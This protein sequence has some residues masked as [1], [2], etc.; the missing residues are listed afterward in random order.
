MAE[1]F[2]SLL[3]RRVSS[4][5]SL[6]CIGL[7]P[8]AA[9]LPEPSAAAALTFCLEIVAKT[10]PYAAAFKPNCAFF[11]AFGAA[12]IEA[13]LEVVR[14]IP[15][16]VPII[17]DCKR[18]DIDTTAQAY[19]SAAYDILSVRG[20]G[21]PSAVTL[22]PYMGWDSVQPFV[23][24]P[25][26]DKAA[27]VLCK[28]SNPSSSDIQNKTTGG[29]FVFEMVAK[30]CCEW[31]SRGGGIGLVAGATDTAALA[32][33][34]AA[35]PDLWILCPG[36]G[37][38][39]GEP[40]PVCQAG[41]RADGSGLLVSVSRGI[42]KAA[43]MA[44]AAQDL[45]REVNACRAAKA[46]SSASSASAASAASGADVAVEGYQVDFINLALSKNVLQFGQFTLKSGRVS[47]YFFNAGLFSCGQS[48]HLLSRF[49]AQA[50]RASGVSFDVIFG[51]A[52][53]GIPLA[54]SIA[55]AWYDL[56]G[57]SKDYC[58]NRKEAKTHGEGGSLV[59]AAMRGKRVLVVDDVI[60]AGTAI[61]ESVEILAANEG[62]IAAIAVC[63]DRQERVAEE[64]AASAIQQVERDLGVPVL[65]IVRLK[66]LVAFVRGQ[67]AK[68]E[69]LAIDLAAVSAYREKFGVDY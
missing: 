62:S 66:H 53:K 55:A 23:T 34:R 35:A 31:N 36:V 4:S 29:Q 61:R 64:V 2:F 25:N 19:A 45:Q 11:E 65:S 39:G 68:G 57:E 10:H 18:G 56:Y 41:L 50:V 9:Q 1:S 24:G 52:Y 8:H 69:H 21:S 13:L 16:D 20:A 27:F 67:Q 38:Q 54:A 5:D 22:S 63:L 49:Y 7:D 3:E 42:S 40:E 6:L 46:S 59:G 15:K 30:L 12:G 32:K 26:V 47:P 58:Y 51:P 60:T 44:K 17:L 48:M 28:T 33:V 37:A 14:A 43:D